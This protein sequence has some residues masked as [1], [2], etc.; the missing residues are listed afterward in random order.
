MS[1]T[2]APAAVNHVMSGSAKARASYAGSG[3]SFN[4]SFNCSSAADNGSGK[5]TVNLS[6]ALS[7]TG[8]M[9]PIASCNVNGLS[10]TTAT[11]TIVVSTS[12]Y[13]TVTSN[14]QGSFT[15]A[16]GVFSALM[17]DLA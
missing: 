14:D 4:S 5:Y 9:T 7:S 2:L 1:N 13:Q 10:S 16:A 8:Q 15:D 12:A 6:N 3:T 17:G 11:T